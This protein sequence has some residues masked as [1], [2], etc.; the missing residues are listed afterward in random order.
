MSG[1][2]T[3][4]GRIVLLGG[5]A[6]AGKSTLAAAWCATRL[7][8]VHIELDAVRNLIVSGGVDPQGD[9]PLADEQYSLCAFACCR[10]ASTLPAP[11][12]MSP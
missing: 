8:A 9:S 12:T 2:Q 1:E 4:P 3:S 6:G 11:A 10:L 7:R 5:P